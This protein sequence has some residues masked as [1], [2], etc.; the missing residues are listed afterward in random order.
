MTSASTGA[1]RYDR[2]LNPFA[3]A[4]GPAALIVSI[5]TIG[6]CEGAGDARRCLRHGSECGAPRLSVRGFIGEPGVGHLRKTQC[7]PLGISG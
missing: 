6:S 3:R 2:C 5:A 1:A 7:G 4:G